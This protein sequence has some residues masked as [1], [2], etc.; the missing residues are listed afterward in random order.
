MPEISFNRMAYGLM[1]LF[2][3]SVAGNAWTVY[4]AT[5]MESTIEEQLK[6]KLSAA[7]KE[8]SALNTKVGT[9][10]SKMVKRD[11]LDKFAEEVIGNL[12]EKTQSSI[13]EYMD[14]TGARIDDISERYIQ[15]K[16]KLDKGIGRI[17]N[18]TNTERKPEPKPPKSWKGVTRSDQYKCED[19]PE[20]CEPFKFRWESPFSFKGS[21]IYTFSSNNIWEKKGKMSFNL[22]FKVV[23]ITYRE[24]NGLGSGAVQNQGIHIMGGY[25]DKGKFVPIEGI[26]SK[27]LHGDENLDSRIK[28]VP[29]VD[30]GTPKLGLSLFEPSL[31]VGSTYQSGS[32]GLSIGSSLL[33]LY[34]GDYRLGANFILT[35]ESPYL[36]AT[37]TWHPRIAGKNLNIAPGLGWVF[38]KDGNSTWSLGLHFQVW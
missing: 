2:F 11:E 20:R 27:L 37:A 21:P 29:K 38:D 1:S 32:F 23:G 35:E 22:A 17:G 7:A 33:N 9:I 12:D 31:L 26:E 18:R 36:G 30:I 19:H 5:K 4:K 14:K 16:G 3:L 10:K 6:G 15:M 8:I 13:K 24:G 28:Y 34:K 25:I